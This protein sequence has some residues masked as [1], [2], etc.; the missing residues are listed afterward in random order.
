MAPPKPGPERGITEALAAVGWATR[1]RAIRTWIGMAPGDAGRTRVTFVWEP[2]ATVP[3]NRREVPSRVALIA[4]GGDGAP[5]SAAGFPAMPV[6][7]PYRASSRPP[8]AR[9]SCA[10]GIEGSSGQLI[11]SDLLDLVVPNSRR[12]R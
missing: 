7:R 9:C 5:S 6:N 11:D 10:S 12:P 4:A 1:A 3:G 8:P 2:A